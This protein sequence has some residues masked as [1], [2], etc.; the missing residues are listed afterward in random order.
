[1]SPH[2]DENAIALRL[3]REA[4]TSGAESH[5]LMLLPGIFEHFAHVTH[6]AGDHD[7][8]GEK[9]IR[10]SI[11]GVANKIDGSG[12]HAV[13]TKEGYEIIAQPWWRPRCQGIRRAVALRR[14]GRRRHSP[15]I[16]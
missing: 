8:F 1:M 12:Q 3:P 5:A 11:G 7:H 2:V 4:R 10:T 13:S 15:E 14:A 9:A 16:G 6:V